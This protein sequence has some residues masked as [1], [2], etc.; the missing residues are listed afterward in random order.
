[1]T[2][3]GA[4]FR[5]MPRVR[6][7]A[8]FSY[9]SSWDLCLP[10][11]ETLPNL[12]ARIAEIADGVEIV[13]VRRLGDRDDARDVA[14]ETVA[15]LLAR[16]RTGAVPDACEL[17]P[18]AWGIA[19]HV[20][21]DV[22]RARAHDAPVTDSIASGRPGPLD[23]LV[24]REDVRIVHG[25]LSV[26]AEDDRALLTRC[27][28][29]GERIG[30]IADELG[31]PPERLRKRKSRALQRLATAL[32]RPAPAGGHDADPAPIEEA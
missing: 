2:S 11:I 12:D 23:A 22:L 18:I 3:G 7:S 32:G 29:N 31:E 26:L 20:I 14:Q 24:S 1:M 13:A 19:K 28:L 17:A 6:E 8:T 9:G 16:V 27:F 21:A 15:R 5:D 25:A 10:D 30:R 4:S